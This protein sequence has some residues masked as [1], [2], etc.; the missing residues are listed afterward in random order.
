MARRK[1][2]ERLVLFRQKYGPAN[3]TTI[4]ERT[5]RIIL[6]LKNGEKRAIPIILVLV[7]QP[8]V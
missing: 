1:S 3:N 6:A 4:I 2:V 7:V 5:S 8:G